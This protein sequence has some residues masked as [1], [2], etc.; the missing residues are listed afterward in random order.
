MHRSLGMLY[1]EQANKM[2]ATVTSVASSAKAK[3]KVKLALP[4]RFGLAAAELRRAQALAQPSSVERVVQ[5]VELVTVL[6]QALQHCAGAAAAF[7]RGGRVTVDD[8]HAARGRVEAE[9]TEALETAVTGTPTGAVLH[10]G[11]T[12]KRAIWLNHIG[13]HRAAMKGFQAALELATSARYATAETEKI[14]SLAEHHLAL[15]KIFLDTAPLL[16]A[17]KLVGGDIGM[18]ND[19]DIQAAVRYRESVF[20]KA[21]KL[22]PDNAPFHLGLGNLHMH[23]AHSAD[24]ALNSRA[25]A[26]AQQ[27]YA[28]ALKLFTAALSEADQHAQ[29]TQTLEKQ[30]EMEQQKEG[31]RNMRQL[32]L[33]LHGWAQTQARRNR[34]YDYAHNERVHA[35]L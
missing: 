12:L 5:L 19:L 4:K 15:Y 31:V 22:Q 28:A 21:I 27:A 1:A 18:T 24:S 7:A 33:E 10:G 9:I 26:Q 2:A 13:E 20:V 3:A 8:P 25:S 34:R 29:R 35:E 16:D 14:A 30:K 17:I 6:Q 11:A 23:H 32:V